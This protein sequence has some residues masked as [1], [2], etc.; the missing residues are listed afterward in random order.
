MPNQC[1][2]THPRGAR[3]TPVPL[4][5]PVL[6]PDSQDTCGGNRLTVAVA[7]S[8]LQAEL[9]RLGACYPVISSN[10]ACAATGCQRSGDAN[11]LIRRASLAISCSLV[12][13]IACPEIP[14][15]AEHV[16]ATLA[17]TRYGVVTVLVGLR[18]RDP[19]DPDHG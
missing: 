19:P 16:D 13:P 1:S 3:K 12:S 4:S 9:Y 11:R 6:P 2:D 14:T 18:G 17:I 7:E 10:V 5:H 15:I 8:R